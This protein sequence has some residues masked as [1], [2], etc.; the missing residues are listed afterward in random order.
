MVKGVDFSGIR[1]SMKKRFFS[2]NKRYGRLLVNQS[3]RHKMCL[4][5]FP[6]EKT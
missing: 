5:I 4:N 6:P 3:H 2:E 1:E